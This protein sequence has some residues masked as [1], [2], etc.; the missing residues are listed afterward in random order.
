MEKIVIHH[1]GGF[2]RLKFESFPDPFPGED[3]VVVQTKAIGVNYAD[4]VLRM[5]YYASAKQYVGWPI[6]PGF[7]F[8]G[9]VSE[10]GKNG[11]D[12][13]V[14]TRIFGVS[15][16]DAYATH[17]VVPRHQLYVLP[18]HISFEEG[19]GF[20]VIYLTAY[21]ALYMLVHIF[22][23]ST[24]LIHSAAG[25]V[26]SALLQ[27]AKLND[28]RTIGVVGSSHKVEEA[29]AMGAD[30]VIDKSKENLWQM[31]EK[32]APQGLDAV[33]DGNGVITLKEGYKH[34]KPTGKLIS[35]GYHAMFTKKNSV[36]NHLKLI[37]NYLRTPR[38]H[39]IELHNTNRTLA[40]F[41]LS[42]LFDRTD[43][44]EIAMRSLSS[45]FTEG[46]VRMP[47][48]TVYP[49]QEVS[50]AHRDLQ[51]GNTVGKLILTL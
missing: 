46:K 48:V 38:F 15:R 19:A 26:G 40:S 31:V 39:P 41:N 13:L 1:P 47:K 45:W 3:Q 17:V 42:F 6:T 14:G 43:L 33:F 36:L 11:K 7:E 28:W 51:S 20:P 21:Y 32:Y 23:G 10:V 5:G 29:K 8:A 12:L 37:Y 22:P 25:G 16:F 44:L 27:L 30:C 18:N 4:C 9:I 50:R 35:Y 24:I 34:L 49:F 2:N